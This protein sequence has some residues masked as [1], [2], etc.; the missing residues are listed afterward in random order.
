MRDLTRT[1]IKINSRIGKAIHDYGLIEEG[2]RILLAV[3]GG[4]D[5]VTLLRF[6]KMIQGWSPVKFKLSAA[7]I[8][9]DFQCGVRVHKTALTE[10][11][12]EE[13]LEYTFRDVKVLDEKGK[14]S[15]FW[16]SWNKRK[17]LFEIAQETGCNKVALGHHKDDIVETLL[18]N[19][20]YNG[21]ISAINP[22]QELFGGKI[23]LIRPLCYVEERLVK[24]FVKEKGYPEQLRTCPFGNESR[25][26]Y[27]KDFIRETEKTT[28]KVNIKENIFRSVTRIK[29]DYIDL[30]SGGEDSPEATPKVLPSE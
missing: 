8:C 15:C 5:S 14:T 18:M 3:S 9:T 24:Q 12:D 22:R 21:E 19:L 23:T 4:K 11:F 10:L 13:E 1:G 27:I 30:R 28:P 17:A 20:L 7:H 25:R 6:L 29:E 2:D 16:C 26:K